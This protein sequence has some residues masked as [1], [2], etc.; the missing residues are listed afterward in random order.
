MNE[1]ARDHQDLGGFG[2]LQVMLG[3]PGGQFFHQLLLQQPGVVDLFARGHLQTLGFSGCEA[4]FQEE[5]R[6]RLRHR[7][8]PPSESLFRHSVFHYV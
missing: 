1:G 7:R 4:R 2:L 8:N 6:S 5:V 3:N